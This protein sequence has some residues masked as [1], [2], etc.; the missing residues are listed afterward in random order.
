MVPT[1]VLVYNTMLLRLHGYEWTRAWS[2][3]SRNMYDMSAHDINR[4]KLICTI[5]TCIL[6]ER[7]SIMFADGYAM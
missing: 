4:P 2:D 1:R 6:V 5:S 7:D 3:F